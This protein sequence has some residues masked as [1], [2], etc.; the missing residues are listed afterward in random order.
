MESYSFLASWGFISICAQTQGDLM[1]TSGV[2]C[3]VCIVLFFQELCLG[4]P[5]AKI[6]ILN[7]RNHQTLH[8]LQPGLPLGSN[9]AGTHRVSLLCFPLFSDLILQMH[10]DQCLKIVAHTF[11][12]R[13]L[14]AYSKIFWTVLLLHSQEAHI[15][16][17]SVFN[18]MRCCCSLCFHQQAGLFQRVVNML[19][20]TLEADS[21]SS[22]PALF[23]LFCRKSVSVIGPTTG[24]TADWAFLHHSGELGQRWETALYGNL[25]FYVFHRNSEWKAFGLGLK[26]WAISPQSH[27]T[28][29]SSL[30]LA[31][32]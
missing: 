25:G 24:T 9:L 14:G 2:L 23:P 21:P 3:F 30:V 10:V 29:G 17:E 1:Q 7:G 27:H 22:V 18:L 20:W 4:L 6:S 11:L 31:C 16:T 8:G 19:I 12:S 15:S 28:A 5:W 32:K 26:E 13:V